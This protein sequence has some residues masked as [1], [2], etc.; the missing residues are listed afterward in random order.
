MKINSP[1]INLNFEKKSLYTMK[2]I[3]KKQT[4][5]SEFEK[6]LREPLEKNKKN[7]S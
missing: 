3:K 1:N 6:L 7:E 4:N 2:K 5:D